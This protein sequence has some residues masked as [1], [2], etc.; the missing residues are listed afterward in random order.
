MSQCTLSIT[1]IKINLKN[2]NIIGILF[3]NFNAEENH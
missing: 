1:I 2:K 3:G